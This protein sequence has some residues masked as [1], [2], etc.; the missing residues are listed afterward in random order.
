MTEPVVVVEIS[1]VLSPNGEP[2]LAFEYNYVK[3]F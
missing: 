3:A 1:T 2:C